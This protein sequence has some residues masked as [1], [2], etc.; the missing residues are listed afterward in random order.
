MTHPS[1][2]TTPR[3]VRCK[4]NTLQQDVLTVGQVYEVGG[5]MYDNYLVCGRWMTKRRFEAVS[6]KDA[7]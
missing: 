3:F 1:T 7:A 4:D 5:E 6:G 2:E